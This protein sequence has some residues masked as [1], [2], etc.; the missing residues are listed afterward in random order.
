MHNQ[1]NGSFITG[2]TIGIFAGAAGFFL[3]A[4]DNGKKVRTQLNQEWQEA[5]QVL[6]EEG[7]IEDKDQSLRELASNLIQKTLDSIQPYVSPDAEHSSKKNS[8]KAKSKSKKKTKS[9]S[10]S[11]TEKKA[12][13]F[14]GV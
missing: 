11:K 14:R 13:K 1:D 6:A 7:V 10:N 2:F 3:F 4:T 12:N 9:S 5:K 8:S